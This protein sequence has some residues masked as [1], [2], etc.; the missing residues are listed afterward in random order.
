MLILKNILKPIFDE[1]GLEGFTVARDGNGWLSLVGICGKTLATITNFPVGSKLTKQ[2][3]DIAIADYIQ[4]AIFDHKDTIYALIK[5]KAAV[6]FKQTEMD[7]FKDE[8]SAA[9][10]LH[11]SFV[12]YGSNSTRMVTGELVSADKSG[13]EGRILFYPETDTT[14]ITAIAPTFEVQ[15]Q[16]IK[17]L[18]KMLPHLVTLITI[19]KEIDELNETAD[20][21]YAQL[22]KECS[23]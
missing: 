11:T 20:T 15:A 10:R 7:D 6:R 4:P 16:I 19:Q 23:I 22:K 2:E 3:R 13:Q 14:N 9:Y 18:K 12:G 5:A 21:I 1:A 8:H 17:D